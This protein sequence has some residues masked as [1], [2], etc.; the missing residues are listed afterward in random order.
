MSTLVGPGEALPR[1]RF[2]GGLSRKPLLA[3]LHGVFEAVGR[4]GG[5]VTLPRP[6][7]EMPD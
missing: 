5:E 6:S 4:V 2:H 1:C 7:P 3:V